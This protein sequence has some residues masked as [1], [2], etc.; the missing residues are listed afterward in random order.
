MPPDD[1]KSGT[2]EPEAVGLFV[3]D[4]RLRELVAPHIGKE[5]WPSVLQEWERDESF[6]RFVKLLRGRFY[7]AVRAWLDD[8]YGVAG[9]ERAQTEDG[10][11]DF[12]ARPGRQAR[13]QDRPQRPA[14]LDRAAG[15]ARPEGLSGRVHRLARP[16]R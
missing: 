4:H 16:G 14:L 15:G 8:R 3:E 11:E 10:E 7:P 12:D 13:P 2:S 5:R 6:P 9:N 1:P